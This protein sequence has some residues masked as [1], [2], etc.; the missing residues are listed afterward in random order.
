MNLEDLKTRHPE[1]YEAAKREGVK[2]ERDRIV[3]HV[4]LGQKS[5]AMGTTFTAIE[6][7][8]GMT[9]TIY[10][11]HMAAG[12]NRADL[13]AREADDAVVTAVIE[14]MAQ[15]PSKFTD[16]FEKQV[17]DRFTE[18]MDTSAADANIEDLEA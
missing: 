15:P 13:A 11:A 7:G 6:S 8:A 18:L 2:H 1:V 16:P 9:P 14:G 5:G 12:R 17:A 10:S 3:A 4:E